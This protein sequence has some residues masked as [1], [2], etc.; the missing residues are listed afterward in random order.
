MPEKQPSAFV[1]TPAEP[2]DHELILNV[3][4]GSHTLAFV[5]EALD[6]VA[7]QSSDRQLKIYLAPVRNVLA[8]AALQNRN[9]REG[10]RLPDDQAPYSALMAYCRRKVGWSG[11]A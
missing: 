10:I 3:L 8:S 2:D 5:R 9:E 1:N 4:T 11:L 7:R 6:R